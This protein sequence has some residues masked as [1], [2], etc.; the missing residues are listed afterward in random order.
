MNDPGH[1]RSGERGSALI[2]AVLISVILALLGMSYLLI[3]ETENR[4]AKNEK[5]AA[6]V[7]YVAEAGI[8]AVKRWFDYPGTTLV[9]PPSAAVDRTRRVIL[10]EIDPYDPADAM[11]ADGVVGSRPYY[12][13]AI[14]LDGDLREDLF[15]RPF[16]GGLQHELM[17]TETG[18]DMLID[19]TAGAAARTFLERL[20]D[21]LLG[22]FPAE[23]GG[24]R[25][26][27]TRIAIHAPPYVLRAGSWSR[28]GLATVR[29]TAMVAGPDGS[30]LAERETVVVLSEI[31]YRGAYGPLH[32]CGDLTFTG[33]PLSVYWGAMTAEQG[34]TLTSEA[35]ISRSVPR[36]LPAIP[37]SDPLLTGIDL[38][39]Y[40]SE[41]D[42]QSVPD[43]WFRLISG[44]PVTGFAV[45][46]P[47]QPWPSPWDGWALP[48]PPPG[49]CCDR[50]SVVHKMPIP[51]C[52]DYDYDVWKGISARGFRDVH[53][54]ASMGGGLFAENG[55]GALRSFE[56][57][58]DGQ[59]GI[60][61]FDT[62]DGLAPRDD[63]GDG[64]FDNL[65]API[66]IS[67]ASW[68]FT[69]FLYL[70][71]ESIHLGDLTGIPQPVR[72]PGEPFQDA[73]QNGQYDAG[74]AWLDFDWGVAGG[75]GGPYRI[76]A[77]AADGRDAR[78]PAVTAS[79]A[80]RGILYTSGSFEATGSATLYG[81]VIARQ[82]VTQTPADGSAATPSIYW[83]ESIGTGQWPDPGSSVPRVAITAWRT[84]R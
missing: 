62:A 56:T 24:A 6:Q 26:R 53:Y 32:S 9:F 5:L 18:P 71:A 37:Q 74:E 58:T 15:D 16:R 7:D 45:P 11:P 52:P 51:G 14:D 69:G 22:D 12:K 59:H 63:D 19:E 4:I 1:A 20:T 64:A 8:R 10:D 54:Y 61:F 65:T 50:S 80:L 30:V 28:N 79:V 68:N 40:E 70:N 84:A 47:A 46:N 66:T 31:P 27:I 72:A 78:G 67:A 17:G 82:A 83:D 75:A 2:V 23:P 41:A 55:T 57:I 34:M 48:D 36:D 81:S 39:D 35:A 3:A 25:A 29:V 73:D 77:G 13:Q 76:D 33:D 21:V 44:G 43:P 38:A 42:A 60:Y 49:P